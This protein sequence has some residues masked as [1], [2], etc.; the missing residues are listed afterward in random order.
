MPN[1]IEDEVWG[2]QLHGHKTYTQEVEVPFRVTMA[3]LDKKLENE[4][5]SSVIVRIGNENE[6]SSEFVL[7]SLTPGKIEQCLLNH[8]FIV[9]EKVTFFTN[10]ENSIHLTGNFLS[11]EEDY[12]NEDDHYP[13][14]DLDEE[15]LEDEELDSEEFDSEE[16]EN[17]SEDNQNSKIKEITSDEEKKLKSEVGKKIKE[18]KSKKQSSKDEEEEED[19]QEDFSIDSDIDFDNEEDE[20][21]EEDDEDEDEDEE[22]EDDEDDDDEDDEEEEEEEEEEEKDNGK[23][24]FKPNFKDNNKRPAVA[25]VKKEVDN[26]KAKLETPNKATPF[27]KIDKKTTEP[28]KSFTPNQQGKKEE[29]KL[30]DITKDATP[31]QRNNQNKKGNDTPKQAIKVEASKKLPDTPK[32]GIDQKAESKTP[33]EKRTDA[34]KKQPEAFKKQVD[35]PKQDN[36]KQTDTPVKPAIEAKKKEGS[37]IRTLPSGLVI[38]EIKQGNLNVPKVKNGRTVSITYKGTLENGKVFDSNTS[39]NPLSFK[40]GA[41]H[42]IKGLDMAVQ[43][44]SSGTVRKIKIPAALAY[45]NKEMGKI[46]KDSNLIFEVE[47]LEVKNN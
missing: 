2:L 14:Y 31:T 20:D 19:S 4:E 11:Y 16:E 34:S 47:V 25:S 35:T 27:T 36:K 9:G 26:K 15:D 33:V 18:L 1:Y 46:P 44:A 17:D 24:N 7:C 8:V 22:D 43:G 29:N 41:G 23:K 21:D 32:S 39:S 42:V 12:H 40:V 6:S 45:G 3:A 30:S 10:G 5:R 37:N 38:E 28:Q 13:G